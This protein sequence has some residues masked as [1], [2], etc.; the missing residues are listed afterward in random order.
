M[1]RRH[2]EVK[3]GVIGVIQDTDLAVDGHQWTVAIGKV[4][5][6]SRVGLSGALAGFLQVV[7]LMWLRTTINYQYR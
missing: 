4:E 7:L 2:E 6:S 5:Q 1:Y 3:H